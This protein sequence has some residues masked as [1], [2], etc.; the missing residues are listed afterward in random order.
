MKMEILSNV[1]KEQ[2]CG[3]GNIHILQ[4]VPLLIQN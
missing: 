2:E 3:H 4:M 1:K